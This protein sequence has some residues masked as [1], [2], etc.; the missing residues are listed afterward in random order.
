MESQYK[1]TDK[2]I[3]VNVISDEWACEECKKK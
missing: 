1:S 3:K 2:D